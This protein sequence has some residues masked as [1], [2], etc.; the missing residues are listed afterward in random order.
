M[1]WRSQITNLGKLDLEL[2]DL[3]GLHEE[4]AHGHFVLGGPCYLVTALGDPLG[5]RREMLAVCGGLHQHAARK[6][7][8]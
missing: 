8:C 2:D 1:D 5:V 6:Y 4:A 3:T 7:Q